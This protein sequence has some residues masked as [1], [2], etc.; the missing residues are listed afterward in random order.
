[1]Q[2][3]CEKGPGESNTQP[4]PEELKQESQHAGLRKACSQAFGGVWLRL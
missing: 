1:M 3:R 4:Q 2:W